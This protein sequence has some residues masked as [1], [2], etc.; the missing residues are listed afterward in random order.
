[1]SASLSWP[2]AADIGSSNFSTLSW[3]V[4]HL[5]P[6]GT[7]WRRGIDV[8]FRNRRPPSRN[9]ADERLGPTWLLWAPPNGRFTQPRYLLADLLFWAPGRRGCGTRSSDVGV[10]PLTID[11]VAPSSIRLATVLKTTDG[12]DEAVSLDIRVTSD[13]ANGEFVINGSHFE[14]RLDPAPVD[15]LGG[16]VPGWMPS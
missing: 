2:R 10:A 9:V 13:G 14:V 12:R 3:S 16:S 11:R 15:S 1:M 4:M 5:A 6:S 7:R 8:C